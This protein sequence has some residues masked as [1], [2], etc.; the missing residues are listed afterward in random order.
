[1]SGLPK[2]AQALFDFW[3]GSADHAERLHHKQIWFR[4]TPEFDAAVRE[5]FAADHRK[6]RAN[7]FTRREDNGVRIGIRS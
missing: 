3:F 6:N 7:P 4:S 5:N 2:R 1:M